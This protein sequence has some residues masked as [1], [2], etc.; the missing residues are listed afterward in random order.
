MENIAQAYRRFYQALL[1]VFG[2][3]EARASARALFEDAFG[4]EHAARQDGIFSAQQQ[5]ILEDYCRRMLIKDE[6]LAYLTGVAHFCGLKIHIDSRALIPRPETEEWVHQIIGE[7]RQFSKQLTPGKAD[8]DY[9]RLLEIGTGSACISLALAHHLPGAKVFS[10][11]ISDEALELGKKNTILHGISIQFLKSDFLNPLERYTLPEFDVLISNPPYIDPEE[12]PSLEARVRDFE[13]HKALFAPHGDALAFYRAAAEFLLERKE[14][15]TQARSEAEWPEALP[16]AYLECS[17]LRAQEAAQL[18]RD[19]GFDSA[20][21]HD[22]AGH[23]RLLI[24]YKK[25]S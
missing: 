9:P 5:Q 24:V 11:D 17:A 10:T 6:P 15:M 23:E 13:P 16:L 22:M 8:S 12:A 21:R 20:I 7:L 4:I 3:R 1:P 25:S 2:E 18:M 14:P 19:A